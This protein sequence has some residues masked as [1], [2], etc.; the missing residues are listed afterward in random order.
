MTQQFDQFGEPLSGGKLYGIQAGTVSTPQNFFQDINLTLPWPNPIT[1]DAAGRIP[2]LFI[3]DGLIKIRLTDAAGVV[4]LVADNVQVI[5]SSSGGG[6]GGGTIDPLTIFMTGDIKARYGVGVHPGTVPGWV[7]CNG[8][9]IGAVGSSG[10]A[11]GVELVHANCQPL[12]EY[13]WSADTTLVVSAGRGA[14][15]HSDWLALKQLSLP[16]W[17]GY[18]LGALDDMGNTAAN[19]LGSYFANATTLGSSGGSP[20]ATIAATNLPVHTH[21]GTTNGMNRHNPH[22]HGVT[23]LNTASVLVAGTP[24]NSAYFGGSLKVDLIQNAFNI[25]NED[26]AHEHTFTTDGGTGGGVAMGIISPRKLC[27]IYMKL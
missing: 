19:R 23:G 12:F 15:A 18:A 3:A 2:Q 14:N 4:Q 20:S 13:L 24:S 22:S 8:M 5:G 27:T 6:G 21:G 26:I 17:R 25:N 10:S 9:A 11:S 7:R 1:L 16:D